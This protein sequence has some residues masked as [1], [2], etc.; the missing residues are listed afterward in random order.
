MVAAG[1]VG[2]LLVAGDVITGTEQQSEQ[3]QIEQAFVELGQQISS[4]TTTSDVVQTSDLNAGEHG[5]IAHHD[6]ATY[7]IWAEEYSGENR[8]D[9]ANG[10]IGTIE[11]ESDDGTRVAY[12]GGAVFRE[13]GEQTRVLSVPPVYYNHQTNTL[14]FPVVELAEN[15]TIDSGEITVDQ[16]DAE[17]NEMNYIRDDHIFIEIESEYCLGWE[18]HF[19]N[20][21]GDTAI[22][23][24][25]YGDENDEGV[26]KI[27]LGHEDVEN[28]FSDSVSLP[29]DDYVGSGHASGNNLEEVNEADFPDLDDTIQQLIDEFEDDEPRL[30]DSESNPSGAY[31]EESLDGDEHY[32]FSLEDG[33]AVVVVNGSVDSGENITVSQ[34]GGGEHSLK[35]YAK[36]DFTLGDGDVRTIGSCDTVEAIQLYGTSSSTV[37]FHNSGNDFQGLIYVASDE[38]NTESSNQHEYQVQFTGG[39]GFSFEGAIIANSIYFDTPTNALTPTAIENGEIEVIPE[40]FEPAP[41]L[42]YL[43]IAEYEIDIENN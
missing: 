31:Y 33:D 21:A 24:E 39:G 9:I 27:K 25:C 22:Q 38:F 13:T 16:I 12:E 7:E 14:S 23:K 10:T 6:S 26:L 1:S 43:N 35:I 36:D 28:A 17:P 5:A 34:C 2:V 29:N 42:T 41:Q 37:N 18:Q 32:D 30:D 11:Y 8:T 19:S 40:G 15:K 20:Q 3:E 4:T